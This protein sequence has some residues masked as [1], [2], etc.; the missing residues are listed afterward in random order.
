MPIPAKQSQLPVVGYVV[1]TRD[2][3]KRLLATGD[4]LGMS[5]SSHR[6][7]RW[8]SSNDG[9]FVAS[10]GILAVVVWVCSRVAGPSVGARRRT[11]MLR[12]KVVSSPRKWRKKPQ[13]G[14]QN[15]DS[16]AWGGVGGVYVLTAKRPRGDKSRFDVP[17]PAVNADTIQTPR[18]ARRNSKRQGRHRSNGCSQAARNWPAGLTHAAWG[19]KLGAANVERS[20][21]IAREA[22]VR[23]SRRRRRGSR[24]YHHA[25]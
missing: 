19:R 3:I 16:G 20:R 18:S 6:N 22:E 21:R 7:R 25:E 1:M 12:C 17:D 14:S 5:G 11:A 4:Q 8:A 2:R 10:L 24:R 13:C 15:W 9:Q 23:R